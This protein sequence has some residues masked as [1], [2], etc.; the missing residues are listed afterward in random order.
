MPREL[1]SASILA[2]LPL[3]RI[4]RPAQAGRI[5]CSQPFADP[6]AE[7]SSSSSFC[8]RGKIAS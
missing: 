3:R 4:A 5:G 2:N 6:R 7:I 1:R 8:N